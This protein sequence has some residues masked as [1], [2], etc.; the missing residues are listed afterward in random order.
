[1]AA[2]GH[3]GCLKF[4]I[5]TV[6]TLEWVKVRRRIKYDYRLLARLV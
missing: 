4:E 6:V 1:M 5:F 2:V 3:H